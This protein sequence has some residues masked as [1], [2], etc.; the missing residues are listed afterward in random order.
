MQQ[1]IDQCFESRIWST[2]RSTFNSV[3]HIKMYTETRESAQEGNIYNFT[4]TIYKFHMFHV[5]MFHY[6][7]HITRYTV[8]GTRVYC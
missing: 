3:V 4:I 5:F 2:D 7:L 1:R 8:S 6:T